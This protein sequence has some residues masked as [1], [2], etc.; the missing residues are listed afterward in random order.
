MHKKFKLSLKRD[1]YL[2]PSFSQI[3]DKCPP[4]KSPGRRPG[5]KCIFGRELQNC[6]PALAEKKIYFP[7]PSF[8]PLQSTPG[9][10][11]R[12]KKFTLRSGKKRGERG[13]EQVFFTTPLLF[14]L[15]PLLV[16]LPPSFSPFAQSIK[17][18]N[19]ASPPLSPLQPSRDQSKLFKKL[20]SFLIRIHL[21]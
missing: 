20:A 9:R 4:N 2:F 12:F 16:T 17:T 1:R 11:S 14:F 18:S 13:G 7:P 6:F 10:N 8:F 19:E 5:V 3:E 21:Y 15:R